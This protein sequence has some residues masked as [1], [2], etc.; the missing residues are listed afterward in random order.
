MTSVYLSL[1]LQDYMDTSSLL[2][3]PSKA[4]SLQHPDG[5]IM[6]LATA[7]SQ[8]AN[9]TLPRPGLATSAISATSMVGRGSRIALQTANV[10]ATGISTPLSAGKYPAGSLL[11]FTVTFSVPVQV[12]S[13]PFGVAG[14]R[15]LIQTL[16]HHALD[17]SM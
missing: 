16:P 10:R 11:S 3:Y 1:L 17:G 9:L 4:L 2:A 13:A 15:P 5:H 8:P 14:Q 6:R 12:N 7:P